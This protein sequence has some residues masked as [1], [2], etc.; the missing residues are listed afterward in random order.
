[1]GG[2]DK[3]IEKEAS[4]FWIYMKYFL[5]HFTGKPGEGEED[6]PVTEN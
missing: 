1:M 2:G 6:S 4:L 5:N 3:L